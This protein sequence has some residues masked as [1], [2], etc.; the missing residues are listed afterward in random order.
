M[1]NFEFKVKDVRLDSSGIM[2]VC[3]SAGMQAA[4]GAI[5]QR[6]RS[7]AD[8]MGHLHRTD[9]R[10]H[11]AAGVDVLSR[12]AVGW[13]GTGDKLSR[14]DQEYHHTLDSVNH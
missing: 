6:M 2:E 13:I 11:Y 5:A 9:R 14:I 8:A 1:A 7:Q 4:L 12:T 3:K 10:P